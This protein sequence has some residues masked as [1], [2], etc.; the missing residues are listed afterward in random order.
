MIRPVLFFAS[1][2]MIDQGSKVFI[3]THPTWQEGAFFRLTKNEG[4][5]FSI[6]LPPAILWSLV[7]GAVIAL[8]W[9]SILCL[10][11]HT[12]GHGMY[13]S[14]IAAGGVSNIVD[15]LRFGAVT[16]IFALPGGLFFNI[17]DIAIV[18]GSMFFLLCIRER[19][20]TKTVNPKL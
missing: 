6:A 12:S 2:L 17:A 5:A 4:L 8:L 7:V 13:L 11:E 20:N 10:R 16:D 18:F 15:R 3:R 1:V 14:L 19:E 9:Y